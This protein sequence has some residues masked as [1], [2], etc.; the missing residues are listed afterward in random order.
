MSDLAEPR[1]LDERL[2]HWAETKP[3]GEAMTYLDRTWT[4]AQWDDRVRRLAGALTERG[5]GRGDSAVRPMGLPPVRTKVRIGTGT[6]SSKD[7]EKL[8]LD[9]LRAFV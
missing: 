7:E 9:G 8:D 6:A 2:A 4:W 5:I 3:D 1:F